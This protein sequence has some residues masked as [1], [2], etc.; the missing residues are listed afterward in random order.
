MLRYVNILH[1]IKAV[2][3]QTNH[4]FTTHTIHNLILNI[5][6]NSIIKQKT[7]I[8]YLNIKGKFIQLLL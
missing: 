7:T 1:L 8:C 4:F 2:F 6:A 5:T 3:K